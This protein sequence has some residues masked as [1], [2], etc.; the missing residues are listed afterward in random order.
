M[1]L[2]PFLYCQIERIRETSCE[3]PPDGCF[4]RRQ[5]G[6]EI[7]GINLAQADGPAVLV[8]DLF[9]FGLDLGSR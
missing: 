1:I 9:S 6:P 3:L 4:G 8:F 2:P 7:N 5:F